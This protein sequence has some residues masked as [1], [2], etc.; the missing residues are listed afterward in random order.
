M[1][2]G[3]QLMHLNTDGL[4][5]V[6]RDSSRTPP[7]L[8]RGPTGVIFHKI[9]SD[10]PPLLVPDENELVVSASGRIGCAAR[11]EV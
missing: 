5:E 10:S 8:H 2:V 3:I 7:D 11:L 9:S 4:L 6:I 1:I